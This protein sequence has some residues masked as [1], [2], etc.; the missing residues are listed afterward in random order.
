MGKHTKH[1][2]RPKRHS[3]HSKGRKPTTRK[4]R[5]RGGGIFGSIVTLRNINYID[6][7]EKRLVNKCNDYDWV[8]EQ[9]KGSL[10][11]TRDK[12]SYK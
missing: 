12:S 1:A 2:R 7:L 10:R 6:L 9:R 4:T 5:R 11:L 3:K 8:Q